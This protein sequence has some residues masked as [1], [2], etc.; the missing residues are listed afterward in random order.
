MMSRFQKPILDDLA[1]LLGGGV[2]NAQGGFLARCPAHADNKPSLSVNPGHTAAIVFY[3]HAGC[4]QDE[5]LAA[6]NEVRRNAQPVASLNPVVLPQRERHT[7]SDPVT[8]E[9]LAKK[10]RLPMAF[11]E[12]LGLNNDARTVVI[13]YRLTDGTRAP[14][15]RRRLGLVAGD[16]GSVWTGPKGQPIV[17]YGL[18][19]LEGE[20]RPFCFLVEGESDCWTLWYAE[21]PA[22]GI[23]GA[24]MT[25]VLDGSH[26]AQF[27]RLYVWREPGVGGDTF[28]RGLTTRLPGADLR[29]VRGQALGVKD[30]SELWCRDPHMRRFRATLKAVRS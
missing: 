26:V 15:H 8:V 25:H 23:P 5:V 18:D 28:V 12:E 3:C 27:S 10:K 30:A 2:R 13:P 14:R 6:V 4:S 20:G 9:A 19:R 24:S 29:E 17:P 22:L 21:L 7:P 16:G 11:L 1:E